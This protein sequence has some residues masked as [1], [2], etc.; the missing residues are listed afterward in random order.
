M[1]GE[2]HTSWLRQTYRDW[3]TALR[4]ASSQRRK[5]APRTSANGS[6]SS[7]WRTP[8]APNSGGP[9]NR[10]ASIG[11]GHQVTE[12][13]W[14]TPSSRDWK[15][16]SAQSWRDRERGEG[17]PIPTLADQVARDYHPFRP[18]PETLPPG[19]ESSQSTQT[20]RRPSLDGMPLRTRSEVEAL[21]RLSTRERTVVLGG[22]KNKKLWREREGA[23]TTEK[24]RSFTR[25]PAFR[26]QLNP[27]FVEWLMNWRPKWTSLAPL[28]SASQATE[29]YPNVPPW[30]SDGSGDN[31]PTPD[32]QNARAGGQMR[33]EAHG[34]H[35]MSLHHVVEG[36][37]A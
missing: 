25:R 6:S 28:A 12:F 9:R 21:F 35:A 34:K 36:W 8:D 15:G 20:S 10:Q 16:E 29:S 7:E 19:D 23:L 2:W 24:S 3:V 4:L 1:E 5:P 18:A 27:N 30:P 31:W 33:T 32:T 17:D 37:N 11:H 22:W 26:R 14:R 13:A